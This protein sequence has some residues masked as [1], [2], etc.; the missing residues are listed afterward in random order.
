[1]TQPTLPGLVVGVERSATLDPTEQY[2]YQLDR[3]WGEPSLGVVNF[4]ML[5]PS[6]ADGR[7]DDRTVR[8]C[9]G[10]ARRWGYSGLVITNLFAYR[11]TDPQALVSVPDPFGPDNDLHLANAALAAERVILAWGHLGWLHDRAA[12]VIVQLARLGVRC[13]CFGL[14][15]FGEPL[16]PLFLKKVVEPRPFDLRRSD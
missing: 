15:K 9:I 10:F 11:S 5:N 13:D 14:T 3:Q 4:I 16:H 1:M 6:T 12:A 8:R 2:R 7:D